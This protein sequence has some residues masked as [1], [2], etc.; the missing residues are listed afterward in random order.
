[1]KRTAL[2]FIITLVIAFVAGNIAYPEY[3][4]KV[5][6][7]FP[8]IPFKLGLDLKGGTHLVYEA[9][10]A[11]I[12]KEDYSSAMQGLRDIIERRIN[13][14]GVAEPFVQTQD[15]GNSHRLVVELAGIKDPSEAIKMI[16]ET[17]FLE[18]K[19]QRSEEETEDILNKRKEL[20]GK[21]SEEI[22]KIENWQLGLEDPY[23]KS[24]SLTGKYLKKAELSFDQT[25]GNPI[26]L[27]QFNDDGAKLFESITENNVGKMVAM[28]VDGVPLSTPTV[29]EKIAGGQARISGSFTVEEAKS[30]ARNLNA[31][32]LPVPIT[33]VSQQSVGPTLGAVSLQKS[34]MAGIIGFILIIIFMVIFYRLPGVL[35]SISLAIYIAILLSIF[36]IIP[37]TLT[38]AGIGGFILSIGMAVDANILI[39]A[40][41]REELKEGKSFSVAVEEGFRRSWPSIRD[42]NITTL[43]VALILFWLG[44]SFI[45]G[46]AL[47]LSLGILASMFSAIFITRTL[48]RLFIGT[49]LEKPVWLW[50]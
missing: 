20:E 46:F 10:L 23:F 18:F 21:T 40:R 31:G 3:I 49:R 48:I 19:E 44:T 28:Y 2:F 8:D 39:F 1:M 42:G 12:E 13:L 47:T 14:F 15:A 22:Q 41:M 4:K 35:A 6:P 25:T 17:P 36:K 43:I 30:L 45:K 37:I 9:D 33:L 24:T 29:Q 34:L 26:I 5:F 7:S 27:I 16:G 11:S 32:A 50:K 38:L